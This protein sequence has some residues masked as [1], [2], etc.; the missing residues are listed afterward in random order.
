[1][2]CRANKRALSESSMLDILIKIPNDQNE[3]LD[4]AD[5]VYKALSLCSECECEKFYPLKYNSELRWKLTGYLLRGAS[6]FD[7]ILTLK[8][9]ATWASETVDCDRTARRH[10]SE[11]NTSHT[12]L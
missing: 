6:F 9:E 7:Y 11:E 4:V 3:K 10:I 12:L 2:L 5:F 1:M 8:T